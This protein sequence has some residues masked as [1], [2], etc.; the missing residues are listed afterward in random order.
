MIT[1]IIYKLSTLSKLPVLAVACPVVPLG[2][3]ELVA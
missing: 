3:I 2:I 1:W